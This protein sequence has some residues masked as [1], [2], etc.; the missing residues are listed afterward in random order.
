MYLFYLIVIVLC[1]DQINLIFPI[2]TVSLL[3]EPKGQD[4]LLPLKTHKAPL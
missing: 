2:T 4:P 3:T 1:P